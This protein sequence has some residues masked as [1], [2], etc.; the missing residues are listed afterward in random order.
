[1]VFHLLKIR[2]VREVLLNIFIL[3]H[4]SYN[5]KDTMQNDTN[6]RLYVMMHGAQT[7]Y[8]THT[9]EYKRVIFLLNIL[10]VYYIDD[11]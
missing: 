5:E 6:Y 4:I 8:K 1:M 11:T 10:I 9:I 3:K 7:L 2:T